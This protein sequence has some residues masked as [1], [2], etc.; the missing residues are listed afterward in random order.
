M[1]N[2]KERPIVSWLRIVHPE[3]SEAI[4]D[5]VDGILNLMVR[6]RPQQLKFNILLFLSITRGQ[7]ATRKHKVCIEIFNTIWQTTQ[8]YLSY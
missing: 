7:L 4:M 1:M 2:S 8:V 6:I 3:L 5:M